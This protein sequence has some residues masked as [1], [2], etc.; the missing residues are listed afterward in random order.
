MLEIKP[1]QSKDKQQLLCTKC[2]IEYIEE[3]FSY[4][5]YDGDTFIGISQFTIDEKGGKILNLANA[6]DIDDAEALFIMGRAVLNFLDLCKVEYAEISKEAASERL[7]RW[8]GFKPD[9]N[10]NYLPLRLTG[11]FDAKCEE[12]K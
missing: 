12:H 7:I 8:I 1:I 4:S 10:G 9:T 3:A 6:E 5:A 2:K 11:M